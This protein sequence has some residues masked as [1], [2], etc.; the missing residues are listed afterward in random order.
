VVTVQEMEIWWSLAPESHIEAG[1][2]GVRS[3]DIRRILGVAVLAISVIT[4][5]LSGQQKKESEHSAPLVLTGAIPLPSVHGRASP[6][7]PQP[8]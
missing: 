2:D 8:L 3:Q 7:I 6:S 1:G 5:C 4:T